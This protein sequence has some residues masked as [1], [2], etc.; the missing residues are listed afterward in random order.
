MEGGS[1]DANGDV[2]E[3]AGRRHIGEKVVG[4][5]CVEIEDRV[6]VEADLV[7][8]AHE[9]FDRIFVIEDHLRFE[10]CA[11]LRLFAE[12]DEALGVQER[13]GVTFEPTRVPGEVYEEPAQDLLGI[14]AGGLLGDL[15]LPDSREMRA[16]I[17]R[18]IEAG[19]RAV[20]VEKTTVVAHRPSRFGWLSNMVADR[21]AR[22]R[23]GD[24]GLVAFL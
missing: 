21:D 18:Q 8:G 10:M 14:G 7:G 11:A 12:L 16:L 22:R 2:A 6:A 9:K 19:V 1:F 13:I 4:E 3:P 24:N 5:Q 15:R 23:Q 20:G 17:F